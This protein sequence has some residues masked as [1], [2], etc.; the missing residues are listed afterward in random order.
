MIHLCHLL[1]FFTYSDIINIIFNVLL[2][3]LSIQ[4]QKSIELILNEN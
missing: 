3:I 1:Q 2:F 4:F